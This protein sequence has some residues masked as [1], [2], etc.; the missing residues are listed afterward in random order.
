M[1]RARHPIAFLAV[2]VVAGL[3]AAGAAAPGPALTLAYSAGNALEVIPPGG[4]PFVT[5]SPTGQIPYGAYQVDIIDDAAD[6]SDPVHMFELSGPGVNLSTDLQGG[7]DK[8][9]I[10]QETLA[11]NST[12]TFS[13]T[14]EPNLAPVVFRTTATAVSTPTET[15][16]T[17]KATATTP[18][19]RNSG[20]VGSE[21]TKKLAY[22]GALEATV[23]ATGKLTLSSHGRPV[24]TLL[25]GRYAISVVDRSSHAG[26]TIQEAHKSPTA[27]TA[28]GFVGRKTRTLVLAAGQWLF[29]SNFIGKKTYFFVES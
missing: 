8:S 10:Y 11:A 18:S 3:P 12:Y 16:T 15:V 24:S 27:L 20:P 29:Y 4:S 13:D 19:T 6:G 1:S 17:P 14:A 2:L 7:D 25:S 22:R 9:E 5:G 26:W 23:G 21:V 28:T